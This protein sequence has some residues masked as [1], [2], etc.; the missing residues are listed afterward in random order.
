MVPIDSLFLL[1]VFT[2][3][4]RAKK[5]KNPQTNKRKEKPWGEGGH[6]AVRW[7]MTAF[8]CLAITNNQTHK[9]RESGVYL[10]R[11]SKRIT[12]EKWIR[13]KPSGKTKGMQSTIIII[14]MLTRMKERTLRKCERGG[15]EKGGSQAYNQGSLSAC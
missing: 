15:R 4:I 14:I 9:E 1:L 11:A 3:T 5:E 2:I 8:A 6:T 13:K 12:G 7:K 10:L